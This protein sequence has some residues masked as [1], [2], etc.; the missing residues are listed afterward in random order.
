MNST[1]PS[2]IGAFKS[3][4]ALSLSNS[5]YSGDIPSSLSMLRNL[6]VLSLDRNNLSGEIPQGLGNLDNLYQLN[7]SKNSLSGPIPFS[8]Q[9]VTKLGRNMDLRG[10]LGLCSH[11]SDPKISINT[12]GL[13]G[14]GM[15]GDPKYSTLLSSSDS[16]NMRLGIL[17][18]SSWKAAVLFSASM[19]IFNSNFGLW[20]EFEPNCEENVMMIWRQHQR[21][22]QQRQLIYN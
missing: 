19:L 9:F 14:V 10:N 4:M 20:S 11:W 22:R 15:C 3:L 8:P 1:L 17:G 2:F 12:P 6:T 7:L 5:G 16:C 13:Q 21:Q 18:R